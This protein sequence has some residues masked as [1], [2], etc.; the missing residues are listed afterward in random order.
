MQGLKRTKENCKPSW[1]RRGNQR[2]ANQQLKGTVSLS[3]TKHQCTDDGLYVSKH[4]SPAQVCNKWSL[5]D[6]VVTAF[7]ARDLILVC[8]VWV[9]KVRRGA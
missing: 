3:E 2:D 7:R 6:P 5:Q 9:E 1:T 8:L 4:L